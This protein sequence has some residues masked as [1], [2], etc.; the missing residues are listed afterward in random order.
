MGFL[1]PL[2]NLATDADGGLL[3]L[4]LLDRKALGSII[5][6]KCLTERE[7]A[8]RD[9]PYPPPLLVA[10]LEDAPHQLMRRQVS[11]TEYDPGV[12]VFYLGSSPLELLDDPVHPFQDV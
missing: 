1:Q 8:L 3:S 7:A 9:G 2:K 5:L 4:D 11:G 10:H 6:P 12:L